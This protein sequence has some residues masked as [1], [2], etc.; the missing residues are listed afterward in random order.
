M[1]SALARYVILTKPGIVIGNTFALITGYLF[2]IVSSTGSFSWSSLIGSIAGTALV[3][4]SGCVF[5]NLLDRDID[6]IMTRTKRRAFAVGTVPLLH[7]SLYS[8]GV[9]Y[10]G[11]YLLYLTAPVLAAFIALAA[12]ALYA[13][14]YTHFKRY[15]YHASLLGSIPGAAPPVI[16][17][18]SA[19]GNSVLVAAV[20]FA[21]VVCWQMMHFYAIALMRKREYQSAAVPVITVVKG[22]AATRRH[23]E[24]WTWALVVVLVC[25]TAF[26][27]LVYGILATAISIWLLCNIDESGP[28]YDPRKIFRL[29]LRFLIVWMLVVAATLITN[30]AR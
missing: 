1:Q 5:N 24:W 3:M 20:L 15:S 22:E 23:I 30:Y 11:I 26:A 18:I 14:C 10:A 21:I 25:S 16:G 27:P 8:I 17:Y 2:A 4:A 28:E 9:L 19:H 7:G 13:I 6:R 12:W 29:S